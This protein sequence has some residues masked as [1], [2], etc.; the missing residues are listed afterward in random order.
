MDPVPS[1]NIF[2]NVELLANAC[3]ELYRLAVC[4]TS[5]INL[6][7]S[8]SYLFSVSFVHSC[9]CRAVFCHYKYN[10]VRFLTAPH[11]ST[12]F[13]E[14]F[15]CIYVLPAKKLACLLSI[16]QFGGATLNALIPFTFCI[17]MMFF[18][19]SFLHIKKMECFHFHLP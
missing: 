4:F 8:V 7:L 10:T 15:K 19:F 9:T 5:S 11:S 14:K 16:G 6:L 12:H 17:N 18:F 13:W 3:A 1:R 2:K